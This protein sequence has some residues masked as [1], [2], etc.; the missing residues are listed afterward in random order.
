MRLVALLLAFL[1]PLACGGEDRSAESVL[2]PPP[3]QRSG[4]STVERTGPMLPS[5]MRR[6]L[7]GGNGGADPSGGNAMPSQPQVAVIL[8]VAPG[9]PAVAVNASSG[10]II[11]ASAVNTTRCIRYAPGYNAS[12]ASGVDGGG[13]GTGVARP[14]LDLSRCAEQQ[15]VVASATQTIAVQ[16]KVNALVGSMPDGAL[17]VEGGVVDEVRQPPYV[18]GAFQIFDIQVRIDEANAP[19]TMT[20]P[21]GAFTDLAGE[22]TAGSNSLVAIWDTQPPAPTISTIGKYATTDERRIP[23]LIDFGERVLQLNPLRLFSVTGFSRTD[24]LYEVLAGRVYLIGTIADPE[25]PVIV[26]VEVA[27]GATTDIMGNPNEAAS[28][29]LVYLPQNNQSVAL[30]NFMSAVF[31]TSS[32][33][34]FAG[35]MLINILTPFNI[36]PTG[37]N[38]GVMV[39]KVQMVYLFGQLSIPAL[40]LNYR[41]AA[42]QLGYITLDLPSPAGT[43][44]G[45]GGSKK[46]GSDEGDE[47]AVVAFRSLM[48]EIVAFPGTPLG[49]LALPDNEVLLFALADDQGQAG[50]SGLGTSPLVSVPVS[51]KDMQAGFLTA[52]RWS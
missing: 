37:N 52:A 18:Q 44:G 49:V 51:A 20:V 35:S 27:A 31:A 16:L 46:G 23:L 45:E 4:A 48:N 21:V 17:Q 24:V 47:A 3:A 15:T 30:G 11:D 34:C 5:Y 12:D 7:D 13:G 2:L 38:L 19:C 42:N 28:Y 22:P 39:C 33:S 32:G 9:S 36:F 26:N 41:V 43:S 50:A 40:P 25:E 6:L 29:S 14:P 8:A 10:R 1:A